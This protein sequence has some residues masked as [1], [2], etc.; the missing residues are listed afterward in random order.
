MTRRPPS[1]MRA[2]AVPTFTVSPSWT[3]IFSIVPE[4]DD[5]TSESTLSVET[6]TR[7][8]SSSTLSPS[9]LSHFVMVPSTTDSPSC[10]ILIS[11]AIR[12]RNLL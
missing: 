10:G 12:L 5:G 2:I 4:A 3:R 8:S 9:C 1:P 7:S 6:S 11:V